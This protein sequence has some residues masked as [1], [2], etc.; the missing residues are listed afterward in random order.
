M[1]YDRRDVVIGDARWHESTGSVAKRR[2]NIVLT[3]RNMR[4]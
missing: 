4:Q 3:R 1:F 2:E